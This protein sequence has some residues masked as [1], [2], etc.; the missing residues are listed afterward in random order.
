MHSPGDGRPGPWT[1]PD[2]VRLIATTGG[3]PGHAYARPPGYGHPRRR[4][5]RRGP[6]G[7]SLTHPACPWGGRRPGPRP[8]APLREAT[9][10]FALPAHGL[11]L[12]RIDSAVAA[13]AA[14]DTP[15]MLA[16]TG[17][18]PRK[19]ARSPVGATRPPWRQLPG[20]SRA[21]CLRPT[22]GS[23]RATHV[24]ARTTAKQTPPARRHKWDYRFHLYITG[25]RPYV[26]AL[27]RLGFA[28]RR[29]SSYSRSSGTPGVSRR[30]PACRSVR[31]IARA[32]P[33][34]SRSWNHLSGY[35]GARAG[36]V[37]VGNGADL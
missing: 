20:P 32:R 19:C 6:A 12:G 24:R 18:A 8:G 37:R 3:C 2:A 23:C 22:G 21:Y 16:A 31:D 9:E 14:I 33:R 27:F 13:V 35:D 7:V 11:G 10:Q 25:T 30:A 1:C 34:E 5:C 15:S 29:A 26:S 28:M 17:C 4:P 36:R